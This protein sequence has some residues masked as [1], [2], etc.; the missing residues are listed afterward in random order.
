VG[1]LKGFQQIAAGSVGALAPDAAFPATDFHGKAAVVGPPSSFPAGADLGFTPD[2]EGDGLGAVHKAGAEFLKFGR[3]K[4]A[5]RLFVHILAFCRPDAR[6]GYWKI[7]LA[8][9]ST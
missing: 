9:A 6:T 3:F 2:F 5:A 7:R 1:L 4:P 8:G